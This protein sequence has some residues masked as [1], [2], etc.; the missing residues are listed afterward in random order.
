MSNIT[1]IPPLGRPQDYQT[2]SFLAPLETHWRDAT[3]EEV[4]CQ[5]SANGWITTVDENTDLGLRQGSYIFHHSG[6]AFTEKFVGDLTTY[7]FPPGEECFTRHQIRADREPFYLKRHGDWRGYGNQQR[8]DK[9]EQW[10]D[11]FDNHL[12]KIERQR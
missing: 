6:R 7:T 12:T 2:F 4:D 1:R 5:V 8:Y 3:C 10:V 9:P 11:D